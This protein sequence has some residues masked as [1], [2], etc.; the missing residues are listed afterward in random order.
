MIDCGFAMRILLVVSLS[1]VDFDLSRLL[2]ACAGSHCEREGFGG[3]SMARQK[4][5]S[6]DGNPGADRTASLKP[7]YRFF[8]ALVFKPL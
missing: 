2:L 3:A 6:L 5:V 1:N 8:R 7:R 4:T